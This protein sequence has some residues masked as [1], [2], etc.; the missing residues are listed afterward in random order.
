MCFIRVENLIVKYGNKEAVKSVSFSL[1]KG[2]IVGYIGPNGSGKTSTINSIMNI[3]NYEGDIYIDDANIK[4]NFI[5]KSNIGYVAESNKI[6]S[7]F[8][9]EEYLTYVAGIQGY[10][11]KE[12]IE[13]I[14]P[15]LNSFSLFPFLKKRIST[16]SKGMKQKLAI[17]ASF[18]NNPKIL[19]LDEPLDGLD[20]VSIDFYINLLKEFAKKG[21]AVLYS[22]HIIEIVEKISTRVI[23]IN[24]GKICY[25][26]NIKDIDSSLNDI[27]L[28]IVDKKD[29]IN[30]A[31]KV[32]ESIYGK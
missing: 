5:Y 29:N 19:L 6:F 28:N 18:L 20:P 15:L 4:N 26:G 12:S 23:I 27:F 9:G 7:S 8:T 30:E 2:E 21:G 25:D 11:P 16:Y 13:K 22:S 3:I 24:Q 32:L 17:C 31:E 10:N 14:M 1:K